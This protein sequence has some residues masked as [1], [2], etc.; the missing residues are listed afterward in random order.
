MSDEFNCTEL[1]CHRN[2][3]VCKPLKQCL[4]KKTKCDGILDC[5]DASDELGCDRTILP[6]ENFTCNYP[7]RNCIHRLSKKNVC[8][9]ISKFCD[10]ISDCQDDQDES[11][12]CEIDAC[13]FAECKDLCH[14]VPYDPGYVCYCSNG[15]LALDGISCTDTHP[16]DQWRACSQICRPLNKSQI[17]VSDHS[18]KCECFDDYYLDP[19]DNFTCKSIIEASPLLIFTNK[20]QIRSIDL[21]HNSTHL[22]LS[23][24]KNSIALDF[25]YYEDQIFIFWSDVIDDRIYR[26]E[27]IQK[28]ITNIEPIIEGGLNF[29]EGLAV[30][31]LAHNIYWIDSNFNQIEVAKIDGNSRNTL[32]TYGLSNPR[33]ISIDPNKFKLFWTDWDINRPR[34]ESASMDGRDKRILIDFD[35]GLW[36]NGITLDSL[37]ERI[38][39]IDAKTD[40]LNTITYD[41]RDLRIVLSRNELL[42]HPFAMSL[43]ENYVYWSDWR[44]NALVRASKWNGSKAKIIGHTFTQPFDVKI[45]HPSRQPKSANISSK[46]LIDNGGCSHLCLLSTRTLGNY[47]CDCPHAMKLDSDGRTCIFND[48]FLLLTKQNDIRG[49]DLAP[50][51]RF[52]LPPISMPKVLNPLYVDFVVSTK[53]IF[54]IDSQLNEIKK[55]SL[56]NGSIESV[57]EGI[58]QPQTFAI[59]WIAGNI[60][61]L[62]KRSDDFY[63][64]P[65]ILSRDDE[66]AQYDEMIFE[67]EDVEESIANKNSLQQNGFTSKLFVCDLRGDFLSEIVFEKNFQNTKSMTIDPLRGLIYWSEDVPKNQSNITASKTVLFR[68][69]M[70]GSNVEV[71]IDG[72]QNLLLN[73]SVNLMLDPYRN[74][75]VLYWIN[76]G[77]SSIQY[78][79]LNTMLINNIYEDQKNLKPTAMTIHNEE[80]YIYSHREGLVIA[81]KKTSGAQTKEIL[82]NL[83][84]LLS[85]KIYD[86]SLQQKFDTNICSKNRGGCS[87]LCLIIAENTRKCLCTV[88]FRIDPLDETKCI[89]EQVFLMYSWNWGLRGIPIT[90]IN[91]TEPLN[92]QYE[93]KKNS[94]KEH[95]LLPP[96]SSIAMASS[97]DFDSSNEIIYWA[98]SDEGSIAGVNRDTSGY[99]KLKKD[100]SKLIDFVFDWNSYNLYWIEEHLG[101]I[102]VMKINGSYSHLVLISEEIHKPTSITLHPGLGFLLWSDIGKNSSSRIERSRLDGSNRTTIYEISKPN[103]IND[104]TIDIISNTLYFVDLSVQQILQINLERSPIKPATV[105]TNVKSPISIAVYD[106]FLYW[107]DTNLYGGSI[108]AIRTDKFIDAANLTISLNSTGLTLLECEIGD[109]ILE[110]NVY[111]RRPIYPQNLCAQNNGE[112][113][114]FCFYLGAGNGHRCL[115][116]Y[117]YVSPKDNRSCLEYDI[118]LIYSKTNQI[119]SIKIEDHDR[120]EFHH[121]NNDG[122]NSPY[123]SIIHSNIR[124]VVGLTYDYDR[125][126]IIYTDV[127]SGTINWCFFNGSNHQIL[128][129]KQ[130]PIEGIVFDLDSKILYW[131]RNTDSSIAKINL[132]FVP[133]FDDH[134]SKRLPLMDRNRVETI[135][136][137]S[138]EDRI[139]G[140]ALDHCRNLLYWTN[141]N[142]K[143][144]SIQRSPNNGKSIIQSVIT[145]DIRMPNSIVI[146]RSSKHLYWADAYLSKI[147]KCDLDAIN[148]V[149]LVMK[150]IQNPF[151]LA[152]YG[153]HLYWTDWSSHSVL[154][155]N[156]H[157][158]EDIVALRRNIVR[159][160]GLVV[161]APND[162]TLK[163]ENICNLTDYNPCALDNGGCDDVCSENFTTNSFFHQCSCFEGRQLERDGR[164]CYSTHSNCSLENGKFE[165]SKSGLCIPLELTCDGIDNC[166]GDHSDED[167]TFCSSRRCPSDYFKCTDNRCISMD[168]ICDGKIDC[169]DAN[170]EKKCD[171]SRQNKF[172]CQNGLCIAKNFRCNSGKYCFTILFRSLNGF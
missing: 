30:D 73:Q 11:D 17:V 163:S 161:V 150:I 18:Y 8:L 24:L 135:V 104:L 145:E 111:Y 168:K 140:I 139:R 70:D 60:F 13:F 95:S 3:I 29:A 90:P 65:M 86:S 149:V 158:G 49:V 105:L 131:T 102:E 46:C 87:Q 84:D 97:I 155:C 42:T 16:C 57:L 58:V 151:G 32:L 119:D 43:F 59:D 166:P 25:L 2:E 167:R 27:L 115:C 9:S 94:N 89:G 129:D 116:S 121:L 143:N 40:T 83:D 80:L 4:N 39:W 162:P 7:N 82:T 123:R 41:G 96:I 53:E 126:R 63:N 134:K 137:L 100:I 144:P 120:N 22:L 35:P 81:M 61:I 19:S 107:A 142:S 21:Y 20:N 110:I 23:G 55:F 171:C 118:F 51:N 85:I 66:T 67:T 69:R 133:S 62:S 74:Y 148:C 132:S 127:Q 128:L 157:T 14:N 98:D 141:W 6:S 108:F 15:S 31:W 164:R 71:L 117:G 101:L 1:N 5:P 93:R 38:Y 153:E 124:N 78:L 113:S 125:R 172:R 48:L 76:L 54:W 159:P 165:C 156:K 169:P 64:A 112:C 26:G 109:S 36:P 103:T 160:M 12:T 77:S 75:S 50:P 122:L 147:E 45:L 91:D 114:D 88:G 44:T 37:L 56:L 138:P 170:D 79:D 92:K 154:R 10:K 152:I 34:I 136:N 99:H 72:D 146:D 52:T 68:S 47:V 106:R 130:G 28:T 33:A